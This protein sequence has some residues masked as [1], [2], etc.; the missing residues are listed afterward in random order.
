MY[1][2]SSLQ[3][4]GTSSARRSAACPTECTQGTNSPSAPSTSSAPLPI[5]VMIRMLDRDVGRVGELDA[6]VGDRRAERAHREGHH[7]HRPAL[8]AALEELAQRLPHLARVAPVVGRAGVR[9]A[10]GADEGAVLDPGDVGGVGEGE[11]GVGAL[12]VGEALEGAGVDQRLGEGVVLLGGAVAPMD[13][14]GLGQIGDLPDPVE[15]L[16]VRGRR[17]RPRWFGSFGRTLLIGAEVDQFDVGVLVED[18]QRRRFLLAAGQRDG[19]IEGRPGLDL[20]P[21][22]ALDRR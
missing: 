18:L 5:R 13:G 7:V 15:E 19:A 1:L 14:V 8:H 2:F 3:G 4:Q 12:G 6:D 16:C 22:R 10:L 20:D 17:C 21:R 11:V 9:L